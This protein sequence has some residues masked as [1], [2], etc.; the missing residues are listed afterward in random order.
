MTLA[1]SA[2][3]AQIRAQ[4]LALENEGKFSDAIVAWTA[5]NRQE[6]DAEVEQ[7]LVRLRHLA[8]A[9]DCG[10][11]AV[12]QWPPPLADPFP[13]VEGEPPEIDAHDLTS[14]RLGGAILHHGCLLVRG[15]VDTRRASEFVD[16]IDTAFDAREASLSGAPHQQTA[17]WFV[18][19]PTYDE[20]GSQARVHRALNQK[21]K[22]M[23][24]ID[25]PRA[26]FKIVE[27]LEYRGVPEIL[28]RYFGE[29]PVITAEK[30]TLRRVLPGPAPAWHQDG[31]FLGNAART[32][33]VWIALSHCGP[34][35]ERSGLE[36]LPRRLDHLVEFGTEG[37]RT[38]IEIL[39]D[40]VLRA[41]AGIAPVCP[42][43]E[44]GDALL[45]D[46]LFLHRTMPGLPQERYALEIWTFAPSGC[47]PSYT[48]VAL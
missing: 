47:T 26:L 2:D 11:S 21:L 27:A 8:A 16:I 25:S 28:R 35:T 44:P 46:E 10:T 43:F 4:A 23:L 1:T 41:G 31:S 39:G 12:E 40:D 3:G 13:L 32:V 37:T 14:E 24:A 34:G 7:R 9:G 36:I 38:N 22:A 15:L 19:D 45:F 6:A 33:D 48:Q 5:L 30:T 29:N 18:P 17:P 42:N 20:T